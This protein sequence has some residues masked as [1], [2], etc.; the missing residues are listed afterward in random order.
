ML[1]VYGNSALKIYD[2]PTPHK[3]LFA[4]EHQIPNAMPQTIAA[5]FIFGQRA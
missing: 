1:L 2:R 4:Y 3:Y 5:I